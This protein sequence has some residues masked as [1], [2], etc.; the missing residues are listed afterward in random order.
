MLGGEKTDSRSEKSSVPVGV[1]AGSRAVVLYGL[2]AVF[3]VMAV[4]VFFSVHRGGYFPQQW[5]LGAAAIAVALIGAAAVP[6]YLSFASVGRWPW[7]VAGAL[8]VFMAIV[9]ASI[10]W[11]IFRP[12]SFLETGRTA[13]Y[14]G[15]FVLLLPAA[16][17]WNRL[18]VD[19][20]ILGGVA[21]PAVYGI[22]QKVYPAV[23]EYTG[24]S[25]LEGD[26]RISSTVGYFN[27]LGLMCAMGVLLATARIGS[28]R[29]LASVPLRAV[30]SATNVVFLVAL[31]FSFSRGGALSLVVGAF[32]LFVL[33][34]RRFE[35]LGNLAV[36]VLGALWVVYRVQDVPG[37]VS[38]PA[39]LEA[40]EAAGPVLITPLLQGVIAAFVAQAVFSLLVHAFENYA[41]G[42]V[43]TAARVVGTLAVA[44]AVVV[45]VGLGVVTL[46]RMGGVEELKARVF[47]SYAETSQAQQ[48]RGEASSNATSRFALLSG[49]N[50]I[51][52]WEIAWDNFKEHPLTGTGAD[53]FQKVYE[54]ESVRL[55]DPEDV[56]QPHNMWLSQL[57][58]TGIFS[59]LAFAGF[60]LGCLAL[61]F[62]NAF[63]SER[64]RG[65]R[66]M[67]AGSAAACAAYLVSF[68]VDWN[69]HIPASTIP[70]FAL[71]AVAAGVV[72]VS[73]LRV[74]RIAGSDFGEDGSA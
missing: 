53:T 49:G 52:L 23:F 50:R 73:K 54:E 47:A 24:P 16:A 41:P 65:S 37:L 22:L 4:E 44:G 72:P 20:V 33:G 74:K 25:T 51:V 71:A 26:A 34:K 43:K 60:C 29:S 3:V 35:V 64:S 6:G 11:S 21:P 40:I 1:S 68:T 7:V 8:L 30:Y 31:Y 19:A 45:V 66:A 38:R 10:S 15:V 48:T 2:A 62:R 28:F 39:S 67:I 17:R 56:L 36:G 46:Q 57:S 70:F 18:I 12:I 58:D 55:E 27:A 61:A 9:A 69:W 59:L 32:V 63:G 13:M 14:V 5:S 42:G